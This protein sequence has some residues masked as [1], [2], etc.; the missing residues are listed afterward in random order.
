MNPGDGGSLVGR[1]AEIRRYPVKS[2]QGEQPVRAAVGPGGLDGDRRF[3]VIDTGTG[4]VASAKQPRKWAGLLG[5]RAELRDGVLVVT[6]PDGSEYRSDRDHLD[7]VLSGLLGRPVSLRDLP[8]ASAAIEVRWPDVPWLTNSGS[9][10]VEDLPAGSFFDLAPLHLLTTATLARFRELAPRSD[11][12]PRRFRPNVV[13]ETV[14]SL[15]GFVETGWVG[16]SLVIGGVP[17]A[18]TS[19]CS[20][21]VMTTLAL[22]GLPPDQQVLRAA[23]AHAGAVSGVYAT[24]DRGGTIAVG[25]AV[26]LVG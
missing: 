17:I 7:A 2:M 16:K 10:S 1:V 24:T 4:R 6:S 20:R 26:R 13:I 22:P 23:A 19:P 3:A 15:T 5:L 8:P 25:D 21:C 11:F 9:E 14:P 12:D 18:V